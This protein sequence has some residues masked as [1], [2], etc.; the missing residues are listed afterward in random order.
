MVKLCSRVT[1]E[2]PPAGNRKRRYGITCPNMTFPGKGGGGY[3][4]LSRLGEGVSHP[5]LAKRG[6]PSC[7]GQEGAPHP[8][9]AK[10]GTP[11]CVGRGRGG[12]VRDMRPVV[13]LWDGDGEPPP[14]KGLGTSGSI[15]GWRWGTPLPLVNRQTPVKHNF[16]WYY[17]RGR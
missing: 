2:S 13:V 12:G 11:S 3:P 10:R 17:I 14:L 8:V 15:M 5:V 1:Q 16:P 6:T 4:I 9:L 7:A